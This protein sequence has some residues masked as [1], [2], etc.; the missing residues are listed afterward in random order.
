MGLARVAV[1]CEERARR[2]MQRWR[3]AS[4][5]AAAASAAAVGDQPAVSSPV[6]GDSGGG[7]AEQGAQEHRDVERL[8]DDGAAAEVE[9]ARRPAGEEV[10]SYD[11]PPDR[12]DDG[13]AG[14]FED[15]RMEEAEASGGIPAA[16]EM[17]DDD[18]PAA[19]F[20]ASAAALGDAVADEVTASVAGNGAPGDPVRDVLCGMREA[21]RARRRPWTGFSGNG[22]RPDARSCCCL[23]RSS[24]ARAKS[25]VGSTKKLRS[26]LHGI[27]MRKS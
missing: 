11:A 14:D 15:D 21:A 1:V 20:G 12:H 16:E 27:F 18:L 17:D 25:R 3:A 13:L 23:R 6:V 22:R 4:P 10:D 8:L 24:A 7:L 5:A 2:L 9:A 26:Q 19:D